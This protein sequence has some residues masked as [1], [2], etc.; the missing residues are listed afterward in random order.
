MQQKDSSRQILEYGSKRIAYTLIY[1]ERKTIGITVYPDQSV[2]V[3]APPGTLSITIE[4]VL[5]KRS[6]WIY[7]Q[8]LYFEQ[9]QPR[10][11]QRAYVSGETHLYL[12]RQYRLKI[13]PVTTQNKQGVMLSRG[14]F[15][16][17]TQDKN[18][19]QVKSLMAAWYREKA[20]F[21]F[22]KSLERCWPAFTHMGF[23]EKPVLRIRKMKT[24]W[25]SF[26]PKRSG[27]ITLNTKLIKAPK[28]C[29]DY[30]MVHELCHMRH[31]NHGQEFY[32]LLEYC[33]PDWKALKYKLERSMA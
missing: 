6:H 1:A 28:E 21:H 26:S 11:P 24:R 18:P 25:G 2:M 30:V 20:L 32:A 33:L 19:K 29:I 27:S 14:F 4:Q 17:H 22:G 15:H 12:G 9:F 23:T 13:A 10:T 7:K 5:Q 31:R 8:V 16:V 3:K